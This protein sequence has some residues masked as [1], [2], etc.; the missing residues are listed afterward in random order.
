ME[1][2]F[3]AK[4]EM[5]GQ[6][7]YPATGSNGGAEVGST[8]SSRTVGLEVDAGF[9]KPVLN[10]ELVAV[11]E[12]P[13]GES[14][15]ERPI[16]SLLKAKRRRVPKKDGSCLPEDREQEMTRVEE[17]IPGEMDHTLASLRKKLKTPQ[18]V[19]IDS[20]R[21]GADRPEVSL[22]L[23][24]PENAE[25]SMENRGK[26]STPVSS[27]KRAEDTSTAS[28][29]EAEG[30][31]DGLDISLSAF[32]L[33][34]RK[35]SSRKA[36]LKGRQQVEETS[37]APGCSKSPRGIT[38]DE[39]KDG[40]SLG[41]GGI[42][43]SLDRKKR[44]RKSQARSDA[45]SV[46]GSSTVNTDAQQASHGEA[47]G[48]TLSDFVGKT[49]SSLPR[50][51]ARLSNVDDSSGA[52]VESIQETQRLDGLKQCSSGKFSDLPSRKVEEST[53]YASGK[54]KKLS[55]FKHKIELKVS[56][57]DS[58][59]GGIGQNQ[60]LHASFV[61]VKAAGETLSS[62]DELAYH[63]G[64]VVGRELEMSLD[65]SQSNG[66]INIEREVNMYDHFTTGAMSDNNG[67]NIDKPKALPRVTR[68]IKRFKDGNMTYEG[69]IEWEALI[70][71]DQGPFGNSKIVDEEQSTRDR[72]RFKS[73]L[74]VDS[75]DGG[76]AA[77]AAGL[78]AHTAGPIEKIK[79]KDVFKRKGGLRDYLECRSVVLP[80]VN[81]NLMFHDSVALL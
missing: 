32:L 20:S 7:K 4:E 48:E 58:G 57:E 59:T 25:D 76:L 45:I 18:R 22:H 24:Q 47:L 16:R 2:P 27:K 41:S 21:S 29:E 72:D 78:K 34:A 19:K 13:G 42:A 28:L 52:H 75:R 62:G 64:R 44:R 35:F 60:G 77:V 73:V 9:A 53:S 33:K 3:S 61:D 1:G 63:L 80:V 54:G 66:H 5:E 49:Q 37:N 39:W 43:K 79:F 10:G 51:R 12:L 50:R 30:P 81:L 6:E 11:A 65:G 69:D 8:P 56:L 46:E 71:D 26:K 15:D 74:P 23:D 70:N 31:S 67:H 38:S 40:N 14:D 17:G 55:N 68:K 36:G